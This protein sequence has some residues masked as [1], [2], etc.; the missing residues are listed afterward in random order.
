MSSDH[1]ERFIVIA[2]DCI[3]EIDS[4]L[5]RLL[6]TY[7]IVKWMEIVSAKCVNTAIDTEKYITVGQEIAIEHI[8]MGKIGDEVEVTSRLVKQEKR[9][10]YFEIEAW[11]A[12]ELIAEASHKRVLMPLRV[13]KKLA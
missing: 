11:I 5:P 6:G 9:E 13:L 2:K 3:S 12:G 7:T 10:R 4:T 1:C 8:G